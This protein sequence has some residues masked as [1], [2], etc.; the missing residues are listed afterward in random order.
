MVYFTVN[1][2]KDLTKVLSHFDTYTLVGY[3]LNNY[4]IFKYIL[5]MVENKIHLT[6][7]GSK[8]IKNL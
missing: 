2:I 8:V 4:L 5:C 6:K 1:N 3:K 7:E